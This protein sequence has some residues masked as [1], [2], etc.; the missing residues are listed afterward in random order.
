MNQ[1]RLIKSANFN[2]ITCNFHSKENEV[3]MT[4]EQLAQCLGYSD[5]RAVSKVVDRNDYLKND[6][7][8]S[9]VK[10]TT[11]KYGDRDTRIFTEDGIYEVTMLAKTEKAKEF[12]SWVRTILKS[13]RKGEAKI[14]PMTDYQKQTIKVREDNV[15]ERKAKMLE[16][17]GNK[18]E[19]TTYQQ[20]LYAHATKILTGDFLLPLPEIGQQTY[21]AKEIGDKLGISANMVGKL[22]NSNG[23]KTNKYGTYV[24]D[25]SKHSNKEVTTFRYFER[26][27]P[28]IEKLIGLE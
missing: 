28:V 5:K 17:I 2:G 23:L 21:S 8:S 10:V 4:S 11:D 27:V 19:G 3:Y 16:R 1:L 22:A 26:V 7:F 20:I 6:E 12:R 24:Q 14:V 13:L 15:N 18:Y 9:V 25:K